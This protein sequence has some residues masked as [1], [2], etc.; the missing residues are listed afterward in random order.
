M[1]VHAVLLFA[2]LT[3]AATCLFIRRNIFVDHTLSWTDAQT[4]CRNN[5]VDMSTI[6]SLVE[7]DNFQLDATAYLTVRSWIGLSRSQQD[8]G[9]SR[10]SDGSRLE[11]TAWKPG[12]PKGISGYLCVNIYEAAFA[13]A[14]CSKRLPFFCYMW[15]PQVTLVKEIMNW[16]E[17]LEYCRMHYTD[18]ISLTSTQDLLVLKTMLKTNHTSNLWTGLRY[19]DGIWFWV[20]QEPLGYLTSVPSCPIRP[21]HCGALTAGGNLLESQNCSEKMIFICYY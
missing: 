8:T 10:W 4:Y 21:F 16:K 15:V 17:A 7:L 19:M 6:N 5:Y 18:M 14:D 20:N 13:A 3:G 11:F 9:Y 12:E 2:A 1:P